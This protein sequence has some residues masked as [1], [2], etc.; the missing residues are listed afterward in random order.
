VGTTG[1]NAAQVDRTTAWDCPTPTG[2]TGTFYD[3]PGLA[4]ALTTSG[5]PVLLMVNFDFR[6]NASAG[7]WF[8]LVI[9]GQQLSAD[10]LS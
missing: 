1:P 3:V 6:C 7:F 4:L 8:D 10:R 9:D 5:G 2:T